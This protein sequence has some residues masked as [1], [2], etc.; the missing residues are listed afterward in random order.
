MGVALCWPLACWVCSA[1]HWVVRDEQSHC[2]LQAVRSRASEELP[3]S[4]EAGEV[5]FFTE[6]WT[7]AGGGAGGTESLNSQVQVMPECL[8]LGDGRTHVLSGRR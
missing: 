3:A 7:P 5:F 2:R 4:E 8:M 6:K 1:G